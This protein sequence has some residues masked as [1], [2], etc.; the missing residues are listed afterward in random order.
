YLYTTDIHSA[1]PG[2]GL[3]IADNRAFYSTVRLNGA[4]PKTLNGQPMEYRFEF[5]TTDSVGN[6]VG[7]WT[8]VTLAQFSATVI[9]KRELYAPAFVGDPNPIKTAYVLADP[10]NVGGGPLNASINGGWIQV[11]QW[12]NVFGAEGFFVPNGNMLEVITKALVAS[13]GIS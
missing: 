13:P 9:G 2:S 10:A 12:S 6:P 4:L 5:R 8:P 7:A 11:P 3:T 1:V